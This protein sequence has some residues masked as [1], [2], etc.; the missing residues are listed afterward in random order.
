MYHRPA[1]LACRGLLVRARL[2]CEHYYDRLLF[3]GRA[4]RSDEI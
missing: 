3:C 4:A 1:C 2:A